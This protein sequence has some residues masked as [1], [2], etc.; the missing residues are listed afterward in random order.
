M[1]MPSQMGYKFTP[2]QKA[3]VISA[4]KFVLDTLN[5]IKVVQLTEAERLKANPVSDKRL[6]YVQQTFKGLAPQYPK[7]QP[8]YLPF[9]ANADN[10]EM[11]EAMREIMPLVKEISDRYTDFSIASQH[12]AFQYMVHFYKTSLQTP[13]GEEPAKALAPLFKR[14][15]KKVV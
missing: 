13:L 9:A 11:M 2:Q 15:K 5:S 8:R 12:F 3:D 14:P 10:F 7:L 1:P 6:P 4:L